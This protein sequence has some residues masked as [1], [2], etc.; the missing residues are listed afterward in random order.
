MNLKANYENL[1]RTKSELEQ[2]QENLDIAN[3]TKLS[4]IANRIEMTLIDL[5]IEM[6]ENK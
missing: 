3:K 4:N 2:L 5:R 6:E 1:L